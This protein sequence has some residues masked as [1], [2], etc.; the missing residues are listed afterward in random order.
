ML[1]SLEDFF[2]VFDGLLE[3]A[4]ID[5]LDCFCLALCSREG[6]VLRVYDDVDGKVVASN[7]VRDLEAV[8]KREKLLCAK[9]EVKNGL[10]VGSMLRLVR[11]ISKKLKKQQFI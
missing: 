8:D 7:L 3:E 11:G 10:V 5:F 6:R 2:V 4:P 9:G 1:E